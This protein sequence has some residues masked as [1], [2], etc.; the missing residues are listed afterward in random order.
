MLNWDDPVAIKKSLPPTNLDGGQTLFF[1][2][3]RNWSGS[4]VIVC[5][6]VRGVVRLGGCILRHCFEWMF[7]ERGIFRVK[8]EIVHGPIGAQF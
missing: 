5:W 4:L 8:F 2:K 7:G 1:H 3:R 6:I